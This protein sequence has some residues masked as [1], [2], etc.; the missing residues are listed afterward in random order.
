MS[1]SYVPSILVVDDERDICSN[2]T[3]ILVDFGYRVDSAYDGFLALDLIR[4]RHYDVAILDLKMPGM[5]GLT[6]YREIKKLRAETVA[7]LVTAYAGEVTSGEALNA[8][9]WRV[10]PKPVNMSTLLKLVG[11]A[12]DEPLVLLVDDD[13][14]L[15]RSLWDVLREHGFRVGLAHDAAGASE[16]LRGMNYQLA[17]IDMKLPNG[18][19]SEVYRLVR[20]AVPE[21]RTVVITGCRPEMDGLIDRVL[22]EGADAACYK[23][24]DVPGLL[25]TLGHLMETKGASR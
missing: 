22:A 19:G 9:A 8:G 5:D 10:L 23:P 25:K 1:D 6:L 14:E 7:I 24:F 15:C 21:A 20:G 16:Q 12:N 4:E 11:L 3:D 18:D 17:L 13:R 2:L